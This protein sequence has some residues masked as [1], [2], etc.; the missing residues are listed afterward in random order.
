MLEGAFMTQPLSS[1][2]S[3]VALLETPVDTLQR[4]SCPSCHTPHASLPEEALQPGD[5]WVCVR[6]GQ[7]WDSHRLE[8]V[9]A[10]AA[11]TAKHRPV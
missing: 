7:L 9:A 10:Y 11:W 4:A 3:T 8:T 1:P 2:R 6:C 5:A